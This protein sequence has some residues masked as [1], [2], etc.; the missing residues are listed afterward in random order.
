MATFCLTVY[1]KGAPE[2]F[3]FGG[4]REEYIAQRFGHGGLNPS[5]GELV[6][7]QEA[8]VIE[9][10]VEVPKP[11]TKVKAKEADE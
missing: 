9:P 5:W 1:G 11:K 3:D 2:T 6:E 4:T 8:A 10:A 7:V